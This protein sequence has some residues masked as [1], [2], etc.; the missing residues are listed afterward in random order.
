M[1][2]STGLATM[3]TQ[4]IREKLVVD[5]RSLLYNVFEICTLDKPS[6]SCHDYE[7]C[8][9]EKQLKILFNKLCT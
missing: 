2:L 8:K 7:R 4:K 5:G 3:V 9:G 1:W 6:W